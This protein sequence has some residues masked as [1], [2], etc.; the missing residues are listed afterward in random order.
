M[1]AARNPRRFACMA[2]L[3][4]LAIPARAFDAVAAHLDA[5]HWPL[6]VAG[7]VMAADLIE[8]CRERLERA[9]PGGRP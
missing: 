6:A 5:H 7:L 4:L 9:T 2:G 1:N 8:R 3:A